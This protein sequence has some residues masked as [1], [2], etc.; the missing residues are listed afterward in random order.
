MDQP[1]LT[2][3]LSGVVT[4]IVLIIKEVPGWWSARSAQRTAEATT[5]E[6]VSAAAMERLNAEL[7]KGVKRFSDIEQQYDAMAARLRVEQ[8][9]RRNEYE[10][11]STQLFSARTQIASMQTE[12]DGARTA[13]A[14][15]ITALAK[16]VTDLTAT[17]TDLQM[18]LDQEHTWRLAADKRVAELEL[19]IARLLETGI[20]KGSGK[21]EA[22]ALLMPNTVASATLDI[23]TSKE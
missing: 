20:A 6:T 23:R 12:L 18:R 22:T 17:I 2:V 11:M 13:S 15:H 1:W 9:E 5:A 19:Q 10:L 4:V 21:P 16:Q 8:T 3:V 14:S 7:A